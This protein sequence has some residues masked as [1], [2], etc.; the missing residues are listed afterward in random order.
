[1]KRV[2]FVFMLVFLLIFTACYK[3]TGQTINPEVLVSPTPPPQPESGKATMVGRVMHQDGYPLG[4]VIVR[5]A[6]VARGAEGRGGAF[7]LDV[8]RSPG[9]ITD[10]NGF[11]TVQNI[12]PGEYVIVVGDVETGNVYEIIKEDNGTAK[13][14]NFP[15]D[16]VTDIGVLKVSI[17]IPTPYPTLPPGTYP[18]PTTYPNP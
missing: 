8:A 10:Q 4:N 6:D 5:L 17:I 3:L 14:W 12:K 13:V 16:K 2:V 1:M 7:I 9:T 15:A 11:F 18:E